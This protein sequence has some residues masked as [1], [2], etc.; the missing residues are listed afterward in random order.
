MDARLQP[1]DFATAHAQAK[2]PA[3]VAIAVV[4][5]PDGR[6]NMITLE[7][8]MRASLEPPMLAISIGHGRYSY[9]CLQQNRWFNLVLPSPDMAELA[10]LCGS[11]SGRDVDKFAGVSWFKGRLA[12]LPVLQGAAAV[13]ECEMVTQVRSGDH[14]IYVG[15]VKHSWRTPGLRAL[16]VEEIL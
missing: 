5:A 15:E 7:W 1:A 6:P 16:T 12:G 2:H 9:E 4:Q 13:F 8:F 14:T 3:R 10:R 11:A